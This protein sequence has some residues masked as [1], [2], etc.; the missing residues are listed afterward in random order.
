MLMEGSHT[1]ILKTF[2]PSRENSALLAKY[3]LEKYK[4]VANIYL[5]YTKVCIPVPSITAIGTLTVRIRS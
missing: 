4:K 5:Q 1:N 3:I 2:I